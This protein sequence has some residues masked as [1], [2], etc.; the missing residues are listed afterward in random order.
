MILPLPNATLTLVRAP[1]G[2]EDYAQ[3]ATAGTDKWTGSEGVYYSLQT[4][5]QSSREGSSLIGAR[6]LIASSDLPVSW[7]VGDTVTFTP[8][9]SSQL[10]ATVRLVKVSAYPGVPGIVRLVLE[11]A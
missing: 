2:A 8:T 9:G 4:E 5:R 6:S 3:A 7:A 10:T 1:G 11:D